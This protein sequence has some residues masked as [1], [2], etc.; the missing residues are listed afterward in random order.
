VIFIWHYLY[1]KSAATLQKTH[2]VSVTKKNRFILEMVSISDY[3]ENPKKYIN[4]LWGK[5]RA[6]YVEE[7]RTYNYHPAVK[8]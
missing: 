5:C 1:K 6:I 8:N 2:P 3:S 7:T 4:T